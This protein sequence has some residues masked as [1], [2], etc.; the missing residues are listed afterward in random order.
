[1][2]YVIATP[3]GNL[4]DCSTHLKQILA[5]QELDFLL[6]ED[7]RH[8]RKLLS[9]LDIQ[10]APKLESLH[11]HNEGKRLQW[12]QEQWNNGAVLGLVSDAG[13]PAVSDPGRFV[14][15]KAHECNIP[16]R[17]VAGPSSITAALSVSGFPVAP[18]LFLGFSPRKKGPRQ[19]WLIQASA[20]ECTLVILESGNRFPSLAE[21][22][23]ELMPD[24]EICICREMTKKFEEI[25]RVKIISLEAETLKGECVI[26]VGPGK[27]IVQ[28]K[29]QQEGLKHIASLLAEQWGLS[30]REA[31]NRLLKIKD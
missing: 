21:D 25:R 2:L 23:K 3:I 20:Q 29:K 18:F 15:Q 5:D 6:C 1:M 28:E 24:R 11:A 4:S 13:T 12:V 22:I 17:V 19:R 8:T 27:A 10:K 16:V 9:A 14:V 7:T 26:I 31:Y 30:K